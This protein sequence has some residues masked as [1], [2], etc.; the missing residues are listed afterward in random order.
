MLPQVA[1][2]FTEAYTGAQLPDHVGAQKASTAPDTIPARSAHR[3]RRCGEAATQR[4]RDV[5][6]WRTL[7]GLSG[8]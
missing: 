6:A 3:R 5:Q 7:A 8:A 2:S 1:E 4:S